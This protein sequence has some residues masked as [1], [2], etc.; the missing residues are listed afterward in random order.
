MDRPSQVAPLE[1]AGKRAQE[2]RSAV[3]LDEPIVKR[4]TECDPA[5]P[6]PVEGAD[7]C[8]HD[9]VGVEPGVR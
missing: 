6:D 9:K 1:P 7:V 4:L 3:D 5:Q 8:S 2:D